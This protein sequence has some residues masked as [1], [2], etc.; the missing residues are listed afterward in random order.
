MDLKIS[1]RYTNVHK[2]MGMVNHSAEDIKVRHSSEILES[3][4]AR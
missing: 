4:M 2:R 3:I 1:E